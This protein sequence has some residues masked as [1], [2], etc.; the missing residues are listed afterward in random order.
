MK[1]TRDYG[2]IQRGIWQTEIAT[3]DLAAFRLWTYLK[4]TPHN[5]RGFGTFRHKVSYITADLGHDASEVLA[6]LDVLVAAGLIDWH[7]ETETV[8]LADWWVELKSPRNSKMAMP[9]A[10]AAAGLPSSPLAE[11]AFAD[12]Q[13]LGNRFVAEA[14]RLCNAQDTREQDGHRSTRAMTRPELQLIDGWAGESPQDI[15]CSEPRTDTRRKQ[16]QVCSEPTR[17]VVKNQKRICSEP[18][19]DVSVLKNPG[20]ETEATPSRPDS[21]RSKP[22]R[23]AAGSWPEPTTS[24]PT[25]PR[26]GWEGRFLRRLRRSA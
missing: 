26:R 7:A 2:C 23:G 6:L 18:R 12:L 17:E 3:L 4:T 14:L 21:M 9:L 5:S 24:P 22:L 15:A 20:G 16:V 8:R 11:R 13:R 1:D 25:P 19:R 10:A